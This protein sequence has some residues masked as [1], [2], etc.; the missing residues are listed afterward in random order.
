MGLLVISSRA[1]SRSS[2]SPRDR[3]CLPPTSEA[4]VL[5]IL[6]VGN[7]FKEVGITRD[8][9]HVLGWARP[10]PFQTE[11]VTLPRFAF[12]ATLEIDLVQPPVSENDSGPRPLPRRGRWPPVGRIARRV[13]AGPSPVVSFGGWRDSW[14][15]ILLAGIRVRNPPRQASEDG[16]EES[17]KYGDRIVGD[18]R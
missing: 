13:S 14:S 2:T 6:G 9:T 1:V 18:D 5:L 16:Y 10:C 7:R 15:S 8:P 3:T 11:R 4:V 12:E 17:R